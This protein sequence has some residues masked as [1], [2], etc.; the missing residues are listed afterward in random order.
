MHMVVFEYP[1]NEGSY[2]EV[3]IPNIPS[4][5]TKPCNIHCLTYDS[6][7]FSEGIAREIFTKRVREKI[8][9]DLKPIQISMYIRAD[10]KTSTFIEWQ[11]ALQ[12]SK[13]K[14]GDLTDTWPNKRNWIKNYNIA[15][16]S[17]LINLIEQNPEFAFYSNLTGA[18]SPVQ[19]N[20]VKEAAEQYKIFFEQIRNNKDQYLRPDWAKLQGEIKDEYF[21]ADKYLC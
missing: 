9:D 1:K 15:D 2:L 11:N 4:S 19:I 13:A 20:Y 5:Q 10:V 7:H 16:A 8:A 6:S 21:K 17:T 18:G 12:A 14:L 3:E